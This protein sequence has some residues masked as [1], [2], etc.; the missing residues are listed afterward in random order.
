MRLV[1][2]IA[3]SVFAAGLLAACNEKPATPAGPDPAALAKATTDA[4]NAALGARDAD[5]TKIHSDPGPAVYFVNLRDGETVTSPFRVVFGMYGMGVAPAGTEKE[6]AVT[7]HH[8]LLIDTE[9]SDEEM[10]SAIPNDA[11]HQHFGGGQTETVLQLPAGTHT[12]QLVVG[13]KGHE[14]LKPPVMSKKITITVK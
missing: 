5:D 3:V 12:L 1:N 11:Q 4:V 13:N 14:Q 7:G 2:V 6:G 10:K 9:L 8:H